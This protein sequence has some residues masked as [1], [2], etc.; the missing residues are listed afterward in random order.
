MT[1]IIA[2]A[3]QKGGVAKTS[4]V[5]SLGGALVQSGRQVLLIDLDAQAN[6]SLALG[7]DPARVRHSVA[8]V[9]MNSGNLLSVS[10]ETSL[11]GLDL[12]PSNAE[13][14]LAERF[15]PV[16]KNYEFILRE[17]LNSS[18][19]GALVRNAYE[20]IL[21]DCPPSLGAVTLNALN[22]AN[23]LIIPTQPEYFSTHALRNMIMAIR[24][25]RTQSNPRL[26]YRVLVTMH[27]RRN[28]IHRSLTQQLQNTFGG[29]LFNTMIDTDTRLRESSV[30][31]LPI[32]H[33]SAQSRSAQQYQ[34][35]AQEL[36][37]HAQEETGA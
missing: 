22:S 1:Y 24:R 13:M 10:R 31:G 15:M 2:V 16:R 6:L 35:L 12:V 14:E 21:L 5:V 23:L 18:Q 29:S 8:E 34:A 37:Q 11:P 33:F 26:S 27:D 25:I 30:A 3:N 4:T 7:I 9:L 28:R 19:S 32:T 17:A 36:N 20:Y